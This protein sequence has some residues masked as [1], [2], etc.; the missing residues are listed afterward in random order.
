MCTRPDL[1][2]CTLAA[3]VLA[4]A[5]EDKPCPEDFGMAAD[6]NC[7]PLVGG[8]DTGGAVAEGEITSVAIGPGSVQ[9]ND[10][11]WSRVVVDREATDTGSPDADA[12]LRYTW[13]VDG[14]A[15]SA[16]GAHLDGETFFGKG[17]VVRLVV[18]LA[19]GTGETVTSNALTIENTLPGVPVVSIEPA[20][21]ILYDDD[22]ACIAE[23]SDDADMDELT[24]TIAWTVDGESW[25]D[26]SSADGVVAALNTAP[27]EQWTCSAS[28]SDGE[29]DSPTA[30]ATAE[31]RD[32]FTGWSGQQ[33]SLAESDYVFHGEN[34]SDF[35]GA[36][37][38]SAGDVDG[39]GRADLLIPAYFND[40]VGE[41]SGKIYLVRA[42]DVGGPGEY[43]LADMPYQFTGAMAHEEAGHSSATAGDVDGDGLDDLLFCGY[44]S[45]DP[46]LE[47]GRVYLMYSGELGEP[48]VRNLSTSAITWVGEASED[49]LGHAFINIGDADGD[50][51]I[52]LL[53]GAY[54]N[55]S[56]G[57][58]AGKTYV[59]PGSSMIDFRGERDIGEHEYMFVGE[60]P[61]DES[62]HALRG[63]WDVDGDGLG[64][65]LI[66]ARLSDIGATDGG[67]TYLISGGSLGTPGDV[68]NLSNAD[69]T[70]YGEVH[71][72]WVGYQVTGA[73]DVDGDGLG[74]LLIGAYGSED[75]KGRV[76]L[77]MAASLDER[78]Q[79]LETADVRFVGEYPADQAGHNI[80]P[81]GDVDGDDLA[82]VLIGARNHLDR[83]GSA[84]L[85]LGSSVEPGIYPLAGAD[86]VFNG[87]E[88]FD[89]AGY[90]VAGA[91]DFNRDGLDDVLVAAWQGNFDAD[92]LMPGKGYLLLAPGSSE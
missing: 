85:V 44:R 63:A 20:S 24:V 92:V 7:Y 16:T 32:A 62:G 6:G 27:G 60:E 51:T 3:L 42:A 59:I 14:E 70:F 1:F 39:D 33:V 54:G 30:T 12:G 5:A 11:I 55:D 21:P 77:V 71:D 35:A 83:W 48:G 25:T 86:Y 9:T 88:Q 34:P 53:T 58:E 18:S 31:I 29:G 73:G 87:E 67:K 76:Y 65:F 46:E 81:A 78:I 28:V 82:D 2:S 23:A 10:T 13:T 64:D 89:E 52:D 41:N 80:A 49:R 61:G 17:Q 43:N 74:D 36:S 45:S 66:G 4:C 57:A 56:A 40:S 79:S 37:L 26:A 38:A 72:G 75:E 8:D 90:S 19:D 50:G 22:L 68:V 47:N 84:Y 91:G 15:A 69:Y